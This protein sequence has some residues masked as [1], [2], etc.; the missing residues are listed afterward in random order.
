MI[1][2]LTPDSEPCVKISFHTASLSENTLTFLIITISQIP[3]NFSFCFTVF[4]NNLNILK[5]E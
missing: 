1:S 4:K 3:F 2:Q 5:Y